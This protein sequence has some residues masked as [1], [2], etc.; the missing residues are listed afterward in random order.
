M[1]II[2]LLLLILTLYKQNLAYVVLPL[3][4]LDKFDKIDNLLSFNSTYTTINIGI[5]N[6]QVDFYFDE[7]N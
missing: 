7:F 3:K 4:T 6:Q 2:I 5:P 1:S